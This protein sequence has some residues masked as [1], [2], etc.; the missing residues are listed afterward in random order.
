MTDEAGRLAEGQRMAG[1]VVGP[2]QVDP[3]FVDGGAGSAAIVTEPG[4]LASMVWT[5]L[6]I[7]AGHESFLVAFGSDRRDSKGRTALRNTA[8]L[9]AST[10]AAASAAQAMARNA[11]DADMSITVGAQIPSEPIRAVPIPG[12]P[13]TSGA[14]LVHVE[15]GVTVPELTAIT[16]KGPVVLVQVASSAESP[17]RAADFVSRTL[18]LQIPLI[19]GF[20]PTDPT[21]LANLPRDPTGLLAR[22]LSLKAG[23]SLLANATYD[24]NGALHL[25]DHPIEA[26][27]A[28]AEAGVDVVTVGQDTVYQAA[29]SDLAQQLSDKLG[30]VITG[31]GSAQAVRQV[32]GLPQSRCFGMTGGLIARHWCVAG[33]DRFVIKAAAQQLVSAQQQVAA[34]YRMLAG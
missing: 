8:L 14:L 29:D 1:Y 16:A 15:G 26:G 28:L 7:A 32:P 10:D 6:A 21:Q 19:D 23:S 25:E 31:G 9:F 24:R 30:E 11:M 5:T 20:A 13:N 4:K 2:W 12:Y 3:R 18:D 27:A 17:D 34:Q 33:V 22:T